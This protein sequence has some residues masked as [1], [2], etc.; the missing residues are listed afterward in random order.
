MQVWD[1]E[2]RDVG[3][4]HRPLLL[5]GVLSALLWVL[6]ILVALRLF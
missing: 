5:A 4:S 3:S 6:L 1:T 2:M